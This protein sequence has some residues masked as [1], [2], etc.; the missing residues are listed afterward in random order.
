MS[1]TSDGS[2]D[3]STIFYFGLE[4]AKHLATLT[5]AT[6]K[7]KSTPPKNANNFGYDRIQVPE[8]S[9]NVCKYTKWRTQVEDYLE[10]TA[11][12]ST[13][14]QAI[15]LLDQLTLPQIDVSQCATLNDA[16]DELT[17]T[18][19]FPVFI[20]RLLMKDFFDFKLTKANDKTNMLQLNNAMDK[21]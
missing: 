1:P 14:R 9:G 21:L 13:Q 17:D 16:W 10:Q 4:I 18:Y 12:Q 5:V 3:S 8:F 15:N 2:T 11:K 6:E 7:D 20:A 19:G